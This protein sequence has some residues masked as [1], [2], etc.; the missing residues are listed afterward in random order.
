MA[1]TLPNNLLLNPTAYTNNMSIG[2]FDA[3]QWMSGA[4]KIN[5][6]YKPVNGSPTDVFYNPTLKA[7]FYITPNNTI[8]PLQGSVVTA[9]S[10]NEYTTVAGKASDLSSQKVVGTVNSSPS[11]RITETATTPKTSNTSSTSSTSSTNKNT[12]TTS[13]TNTTPV[14]STNTGGSG[15]S[16]PTYA[17]GYAAGVASAQ[18]G[19]DEVNA[20]LAALENPKKWTADELAEYYNVQDIY[21]RD[22]LLNNYNAATNDYY[23]ALIKE[24]NLDRN[25]VMQTGINNYNQTINDYLTNYKYANDT[26][27]R[28]NTTAL[29]ALSTYLGAQDLMGQYDMAMLQSVNQLDKARQAEL[30]NNP[31]LAEQR[32]NE[33]GSQLMSW[34]TNE[35]ESAVRNYVNSL[36]AMSQY[37]SGQR[38]YE[39]ALANATATKYQGLA[40]AAAAGASKQ[41]N[42]TVQQLIDYYNAIGYNGPNAAYTLG[43][44]NYGNT[45]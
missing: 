28:R 42:D 36:D 4:A 43:N 16:T 30:A 39:A 23:D 8:Q 1:T 10:K 3:N 11:A 27:G 13:T 37:Y 2:A 14:V 18:A 19:W 7:F 41:A 24:Q 31:Y 17:D 34:G 45:K 29:N 21:N 32:Y 22:Y 6:M 15:V 40:S 35:Y 25:K 26:L 5:T 20:R 33:I 9:L 38:Q 44:I 12:S